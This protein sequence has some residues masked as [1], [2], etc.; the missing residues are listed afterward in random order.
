[1]IIP[2]K[3]H[4][5]NVHSHRI[6]PIIHVIHTNIAI[7]NLDS[8]RKHQLHDCSSIN[9]TRNHYDYIY[10]VTLSLSHNANNDDV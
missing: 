5:S 1:M 8:E 4:S 9:I 7:S 3:K 10:K 6:L 2:E